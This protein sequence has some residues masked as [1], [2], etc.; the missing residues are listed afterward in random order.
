M[1]TILEQIDYY[2]DEEFSKV[3]L[4]ASLG[5]LSLIEENNSIDSLGRIKFNKL[6]KVAEDLESF[7]SGD[8]IRKEKKLFIKYLK[9]F[10]SRPV[11][12]FSLEDLLVLERDYILPIIDGKFREIGWTRRYGWF[13]GLFFVLPFDI[14]LLL[15]IGKFYFYFPILSVYFLISS[16]LARR[17]AKKKNR[18]W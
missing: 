8:E 5:Y 1:K 10:V 11:A 6:K 18:L 15:L 16:L 7:G 9:T 17:K 3:F 2:N 14:F 12:D 4:S 13:L